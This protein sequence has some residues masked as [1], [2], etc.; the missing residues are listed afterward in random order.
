MNESTLS[1]ATESESGASLDSGAP[2]TGLLEA[3]TSLLDQIECALATRATG[4]RELGASRNEYRC[5]SG[6]L[7]HRSARLGAACPITIEEPRDALGGSRSGAEKAR[8]RTIFTAR[9]RINETFRSGHGL[10][11]LGTRATT[12][13]PS[14]LRVR[15]FVASRGLSKKERAGRD[16]C[17]LVALAHRDDPQGDDARVLE[18]RPRR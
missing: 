13:S 17:G 14:R 8:F 9:R 11:L 1:G 15:G 3:A 5:S 2:G 12:V 16:G 4:L 10:V 7:A 18:E 6:T